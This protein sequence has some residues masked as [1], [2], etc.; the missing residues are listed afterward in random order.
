MTLGVDIS[1][2]HRYKGEDYTYTAK[3]CY[4][5]NIT[6]PPFPKHRSLNNTS[7]IFRPRTISLKNRL[8]P[9]VLRGR[10]ND[11]EMSGVRLSAVF[12]CSQRTLTFSTYKGNRLRI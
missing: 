11:L 4:L 7:T 9:F 10:G 8:L 1:V 3:H 12:C 2:A 6:D 5:P